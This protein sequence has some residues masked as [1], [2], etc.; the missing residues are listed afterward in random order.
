MPADSRGLRL[1]ILG[2]VVV[3]L[4][5]ALFGRLWF[6]QVPDRETYQQVAAANQ[7]REVQIPPMRGRILDRTGRILADNRRTLTVVVDRAAIRKKAVRT[8]L[9]LR[10]AGALGTTPEQLDERFQSQQ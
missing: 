9:F 10:L 8:E 5:V 4:F 1:S 3:S 2:I 7:L 6:L